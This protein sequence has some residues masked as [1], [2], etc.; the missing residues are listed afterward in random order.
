MK[1]LF[2]YEYHYDDPGN[3]IPREETIS[4]DTGRK[5]E[6]SAPLLRITS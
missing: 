4:Y 1:S 6:S 5:S 2:Q 3:W